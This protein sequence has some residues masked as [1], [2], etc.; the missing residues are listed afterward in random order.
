MRNAFAATAALFAGILLA[1]ISP[2]QA[3]S[4]NPV[5]G[6][7]NVNYQFINKSSTGP[8]VTGYITVTAVN[9]AAQHYVSANLGPRA[10]QSGKFSIVSDFAYVIAAKGFISTGAG[11]NCGPNQVIQTP[12]GQFPRR[13]KVVA[14]YQHAENPALFSCTLTYISH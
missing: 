14:V 6:M 11:I 13:S 12:T 7:T 3:A 5:P 10:S 8:V 1:G 2:A 9:I 4:T